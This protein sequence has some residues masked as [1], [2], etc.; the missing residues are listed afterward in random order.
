MQQVNL[1]C[2]R[3]WKTYSKP[4]LRPELESPASMNRIER[5]TA[6]LLYLQEKAR[7]SEDIARH[8]EV[9]R[10]TVLRDVQALSEM[11]VPVIAREGAGGGYSLPEDYSLD[12]L[13]LTAHEAF[14][15]LM[16]LRALIRLADSP[17]AR[18]RASLTAKLRSL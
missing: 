15:L 2:L 13:A 7:T 6:I 4:S 16:S 5:M 12:P 11:G 8:F 17:F 3:N 18:E 9:S 14:L 1:S 10:R